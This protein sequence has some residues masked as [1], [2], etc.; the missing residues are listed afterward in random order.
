MKKFLV[1]VLAIAGLVA[2]H[3]E[4]AVRLPEHNQAIAFADAFVENATRVADPSITKNTL[5][6]FDVWA[7]MDE[8]NGTMLKEERVT[9]RGDKWSYQNVQ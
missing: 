7:W 6:A 1:S 9:E 8:K 5:G 3:N 4:E 2:C